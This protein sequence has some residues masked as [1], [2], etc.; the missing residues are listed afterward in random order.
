MPDN[1]LFKTLCQKDTL[2]IG[3]H[4]A[5]TDSRDDFLSDPNGYADYAS[6]L[7]ERIDY[8]ISEI[9]SLRFRPRHLIEVQVPKSGLSVR[10]GNVLPIGES[11]VLHAITYLIAPRID[12]YLDGQVYSY[13]LVG[14]WEKKIKK[15]R[16]LFREASRE[17]PF[18]K[19]KTV[20]QF[21]P[22][23]SW[24]EAWPDFQNA[25]SSAVLSDGYTHLTKTDITA[26]FENI[27][28]RTLEAL[29]RRYLPNEPRLIRLLMRV[30]GS[31]TRRTSSGIP[32]GR[33]IPQ[34]SDV[35]SFLGNIYLIPLD[36]E[37]KKFCKSRDAKWFRYVDDV[38]V[39]TKSERDARDVVYLVNEE[40]RALHLNL[41][42]SKTQILTGAKLIAELSTADDK[43]LDS[44]SQALSKLK[45]Q[46]K[47][48]QKAVSAE[49]LKL[50]PLAGRYRR[51]LPNSIVGLNRSE[52]RTLRRLMTCYGMA[53]RPYLK[54]VALSCLQ[55]LPEMRILEKSLKYLSNLD[56]KYHGEAIK[57]LLGMLENGV[58]PLP[59]QAAIVIEKIGMMHPIEMVSIA[60]TVRRY[61][62]KKGR[63]WMVK[64]KAGETIAQY[65]YREG[66]AES[67]SRKL[68]ADSEPWVR[69]AGMVVLTRTSVENV[70]N[71]L[72]ELIY[73]PDPPVS[74]M[75]LFYS[76]HLRDDEFAR[77]AL[78]SIRK[79]NQSDYSISKQLPRL[80]LLTCSKSRTLLSD[81]SE[82]LGAIETKSV[83]LQAHFN[84]LRARAE[85]G[86]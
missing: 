54:S 2:Q 49:L 29:L 14:D 23:A 5:Q 64:Q 34:G 55:E 37:L 57:K 26:Y 33:G 19:K 12:K 38:E 47:V 43:I 66:Y 8:L 72:D 68:L 60:S 11:M 62:L 74:E 82:Y 17:I 3:W 27:D 6:S 76:R 61:G 10:P 70:H 25:R 9:E 48:D 46:K 42:G 32:V 69:R 75:A 44:A 53:G 45:S 79:S 51:G 78:S 73:S 16:G 81:I 36:S 1:Q 35:S 50:R 22:F 18:L 80:W 71:R 39:Y 56:Y 67:V 41:Q 28:L 84:S 15:G 4:L 58:F 13:R 85:R 20:R 24:Y 30:L 7:P 83:R 63:N 40:L 59:Y 77:G 21:D 86:V 31:W 65:P 52:D